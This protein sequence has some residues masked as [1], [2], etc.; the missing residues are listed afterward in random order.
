MAFI[1]TTANGQLPDQAVVAG[2]RLTGSPG[3]SEGRQ[4]YLQWK[5]NS[6]IYRC[7]RNK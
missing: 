6:E 2:T 3:H 1:C 7:L 5:G 4:Y